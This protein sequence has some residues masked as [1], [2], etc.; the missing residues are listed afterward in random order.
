ML[1]AGGREPLLGRRKP[2]LTGSLAATGLQMSLQQNR[3]ACLSVEPELEQVLSWF[4]ADSTM[5]RAAPSKLWDGVTWHRPVMDKSRAFT[6]EDPWYGFLCGGHVIDLYKAMQADSFGLRQRV[7]ACFG[8]P[9]WMELDDIRQACAALPTA[10]QKPE[11]YVAGLLF[12]LLRWSVKDTAGSVYTPCA[13]DGAAGLVDGNF[14]A[15]VS[16]QKETFLK[17][18]CHEEAKYHGKLRTKFNRL[19]IAMHVLSA[20][21]SEWRQHRTANP[22]ATVEGAWGTTF[23]VP[24]KIPAHVFKFAYAFA[25]HCENIWALLDFARSSH[26]LPPLAGDV[27]V[28][29]TQLRPDALVAPEKEHDI[30]AAVS[31]LITVITHAKQKV[32]ENKGNTLWG[33]V[34]V[35]DVLPLD[36]A[37]VPGLLAKLPVAGITLDVVYQLAVKILSFPGR[38]FSWARNDAWKKALCRVV[39][40][41]KD[42]PQFAVFIACAALSACG[43]G[44]IVKSVKAA[45]GGRDIF[46]L[47]KRT[48]SAALHSHLAVFGIST[49]STPSLYDYSVSVAAETTPPSRAPRVTI[50]DNLPLWGRVTSYQLS[51]TDNW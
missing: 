6:V 12:P 11:D 22:A 51:I 29:G 3:G 48:V 27:D 28:V 44:R 21:C 31:K 45:G 41:C 39:V 18:G 5:D 1:G 13:D 16:M 33:L 35:S 32:A 40:D 8:P 9:T 15:H 20:V 26:K 43:L 10:S 36:N 34:P 2:S 7:T 49:E 24:P 14:N 19:T 17:P 38:W 25:D 46:F 4:T 37:A 23:A 47:E 42:M 30:T 50:T